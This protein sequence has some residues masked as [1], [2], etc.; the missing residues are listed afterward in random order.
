MHEAME[1]NG[2]ELPEEYLLA[3]LSFTSDHTRF[4]KTMR[5]D[6]EKKQELRRNTEFN[7]AKPDTFN[8][9]QAS[10]HDMVE[11]EAPYQDVEEGLGDILDGFQQKTEFLKVVKYNNKNL[12][13]EL[14]DSKRLHHA[15]VES[16][17]KY[18]DIPLPILLKIKQGT[19]FVPSVYTISEGVSV[20]F[21]QSLRSLEG[22]NESKLYK[23]IFQKN[24]MNDMI[25]SNVLKGL[26]A[27]PE[28]VSLISV[29]NDLGDHAAQ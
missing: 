12:G 4:F 3:K 7:F 6:Q 23:A 20:A 9:S 11:S 15:F 17:I 16:A 18:M 19:L 1:Y 8:D 13:K 24:K 14:T 27:R 10:V 22:L 2:M 29:S 28:F 5:K 25:F 26:R 21:M